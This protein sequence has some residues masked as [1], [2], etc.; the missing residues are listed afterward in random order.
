MDIF[1]PMSTTA[2]HNKIT[3]TLISSV[4]DLLRNKEAH[5]FL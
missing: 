2:R 3:T 4:I 1:M 5:A